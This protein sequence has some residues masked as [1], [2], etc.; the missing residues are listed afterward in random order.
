MEILTL[1][2]A[3][4]KRKKGTFLSIVF[5]MLIIS[6]VM[7][8]IFSVQ[9]NYRNAVKDALY[10]EAACDAEIYIMEHDLN[11][12]IRE[13]IEGSELVGDV[14]YYDYLIAGSIKTGGTEETADVLTKMWKGISIY[15]EALTGFEGGEVKIQDGEIYIPLGQKG[16]YHCE[17]GDK[18]TVKFYDKAY[19]F[20]LK[21]FVQE[22]MGGGA[23]F[24][25]VKFFISNGDYDS[26][27][28]ECSPF[29]GEANPLEGCAV[30]VNKAAGCDLTPT[31]FMREL[32]IEIKS[33]T[34]YVAKSTQTRDLSIEWTAMMPDIITNMALV[35]VAFLF[36][37]VLIVMSHC[38]GSEMETDYVTIGILK[39]QGFDNGKIRA[40]FIWRY[41][42]AQLI[43]I[44]AGSVLAIPVEGA[45]SKICMMVTGILPKRGIY[46]GKSAL[47]AA[48]ILS[49]CTALILI[50][51]RKAAK[52]SPVRAILGGREEI[53]FDSRIM[54]PVTQK[55]LSVTI[56]LRQVTSAVSRYA[57]V[58][59][60]VG[61]LTFFMITVN[62][63]GNILSS[64]TAQSAMGL[65]T[66]NM[67]IQIPG[68]STKSVG[69]QEAA[70][71]EAEA[72]VDKKEGIFQKEF[73][74]SS[75]VFY[76]G[77]GI[78]CKIYKYPED[79]SSI[80][81]G[82]APLYENEVVITE[83]V[84]E[85]YDLKIGDKMLLSYEE[86]EEEFL[87]SGFFQKSNNSGVVA[88]LSFEGADRLDIPHSRLELGYVFDDLSELSRIKQE[89]DEKLGDILQVEI[90]E[91]VDAAGGTAYSQLVSAM[92]AFIYLFSMV[93]A[94]V[95]VRMVCQKA[96]VRERTDIGIYKAIGFT[97]A[98][99]RF[100]FAVRFLITALIGEV[101]GAVFSASASERVLTRAFRM[102][103]ITKV[104]CD[105]DMPTVMLP[106]L[107]IG[108]A[109]FLFSYLA[110]GKIRRV[111]VKELVAE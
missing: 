62:L 24:Y 110:S 61:I 111:A 71:E 104:Y 57:G 40:L 83:I 82:R 95:V 46:V 12:G 34:G 81:K 39:S 99:L 31:K 32:G 74:N 92:K 54:V 27:L 53:Y 52:I 26:I 9:D 80:L 75:N 22:P 73:R 10:G 106:A 15:N 37:I 18:F 96:F 94:F 107:F 41:L 90:Y 23:N 7:T 45:I 101:F 47:F 5:L 77:E 79:M 69:E 8:S 68:N 36:V 42:L 93:F 51:T 72:L 11:D 6:A 33:K 100:G 35:F 30:C 103:G 108:I 56:A 89:L 102:I 2:K 86:K 63:I 97:S 91:D 64:K 38:I 50:K 58:L 85:M 65:Y 70:M 1:L 84:A 43:G 4:I 13:A 59:F 78:L 60:I 66:P 17:T 44:A 29:S 14:D 87:I 49:V 19:E 67:Q 98:K 3:D 109:F 25:G 55:M 28:K 21:G 16:R 20:T 88:A 48:V 76:N 105:F